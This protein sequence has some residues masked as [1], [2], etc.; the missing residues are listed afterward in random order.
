[1]AREVER[2]ELC[3]GEGYIDPWMGDGVYRD[4]AVTC[5]VCEGAGVK[6]IDNQD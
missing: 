6:E 4:G 1:M 2:C 5:P 3:K